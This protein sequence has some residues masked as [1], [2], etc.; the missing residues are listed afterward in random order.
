MTWRW[1]G[2]SR[3]ASAADVR[4]HSRPSAGV[5]S[6]GTEDV[7]SA[8]A[9]YLPVNRR[10]HKAIVSCAIDLTFPLKLGFRS[11]NNQPLHFMCIDP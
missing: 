4:S 11:T 3:P 1:A 9:V 2:P 7:R 6:A 8:A 10:Q 5:D